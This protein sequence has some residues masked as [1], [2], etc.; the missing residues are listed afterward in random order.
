MR[1]IL[2]TGLFPSRHVRSCSKT[3]LA[4]R[5]NANITQIQ[6]SL[7]SEFTKASCRLVCRGL[8]RRKDLT[9]IIEFLIRKTLILFPFSYDNGSV[10]PPDEQFIKNLSEDLKSWEETLNQEAEHFTGETLLSRE[11][12]LYQMN[13]EVDGWTDVALKVNK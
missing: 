12:E 2:A 10:R 1:Q 5:L 11:D 13:R 3:G 9:K 6:I 7:K 4:V 8:R